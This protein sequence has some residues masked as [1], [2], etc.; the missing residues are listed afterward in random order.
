MGE[1]VRA[2]NLDMSDEEHSAS[3]EQIE[4]WCESYLT[5]LEGGAEASIQ[6]TVK[7]KNRKGSVPRAAAQLSGDP[8][9]VCAL[10]ARIRQLEARGGLPVSP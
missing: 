9:L 7:A 8:G 3:L 4:A 1:R 10:V 2:L 5:D 6:V